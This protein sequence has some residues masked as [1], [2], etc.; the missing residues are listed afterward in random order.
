MGINFEKEFITKLKQQDHSAFNRFYLETVDM[1]FR[2]IQ[3][4]YFLSKE[5]SQDIISD[6]YVK[7]RESMK[8]FRENESFSWYFR[9]IF[10][11]LIKDHFKKNHETPFTELD[12]NEDNLSFEDT[13][14][15][16]ENIHTLMN[17]QFEFE[18]IQE[19]IKELDDGSRDILYWKFIESKNNEE[20]QMILWI[21]NENVRQRISRAIKL[22]KEILNNKL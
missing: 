8:N 5:D 2:Y 19:A 20:I 3:G 13:I 7:I 10:R 9:T 4:N 17:Q 21:S 14:V 12:N 15:D 16:E 18:N 6:F 22:L 1:L 11:N